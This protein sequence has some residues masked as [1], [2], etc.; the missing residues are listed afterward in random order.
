MANGEQP[1]WVAGLRLVSRALVF[2]LIEGILSDFDI[3]FSHLEVWPRSRSCTTTP[4]L[5]AFTTN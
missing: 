4:F 3:V 5:S 1:R 2:E